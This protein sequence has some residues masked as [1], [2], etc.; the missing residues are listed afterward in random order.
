MKN[1]FI[2]IK[3]LMPFMTDFIQIRSNRKGVCRQWSFKACPFEDLEQD[4]SHDFGTETNIK[5]MQFIVMKSD[6]EVSDCENDNKPTIG[7]I[8]EWNDKKWSVYD[9]VN[10]AATITILAREYIRC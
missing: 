10:D 8:V 7:D 4:P 2:N 3:S 9:T 6:L 5:K 1:P